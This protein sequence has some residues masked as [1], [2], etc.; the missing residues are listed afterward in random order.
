MKITVAFLASSL[1]SSG[2]FAQ[3]PD[4][5]LLAEAMRIKVIDNHSHPPKLVGPG[6]K[7]DDFDALPCDPISQMD[8]PFQTRPENPR[9][10][11]AWKALWAYP[12]NDNSPEHVKAVIAA[13]Q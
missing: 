5:G 11:K 2:I 10:L 1:L 6:E 13:K 9:I 4:P 8:P 7:D 3:T 12:Y